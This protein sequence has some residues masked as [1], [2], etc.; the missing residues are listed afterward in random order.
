MS[1]R[2]IDKLISCIS[3]LPGMGY[4]SAVRIVVYMLK[5]KNVVM[6]YLLKVM[7]VVYRNSKTCEICGNV[8]VVSPC[9]ICSNLKRDSSTICVVS[10]ISDLWSVERSGFYKG[11]YHI[12]GGKLSAVE[13][14]RPEDLSIDA[15]YGRIK[16]SDEIREIIMAMSADLDGQ[17]TM[18]FVNNR[19]KE[20]GVKITTLANGVPVGGELEYLDDGTIIAAFNQRRNV[21]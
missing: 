6:E 1:S 14:I 19:I 3:R 15:L 7:E 8:D 18:F 5:R 20:L 16:S 11:K 10:D 17:T 21:E 4:R 13:G 12:L 9:S 2:E